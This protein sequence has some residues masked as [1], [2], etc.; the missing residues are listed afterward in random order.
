MQ[1][2]SANAGATDSGK[3]RAVCAG[4]RRK[5]KDETMTSSGRDGSGRN[6]PREIFVENDQQQRDDVH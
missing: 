1:L 6:E 5:S 4:F 2:I 3:E